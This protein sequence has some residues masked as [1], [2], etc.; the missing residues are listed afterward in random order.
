MDNDTKRKI[1]DMKITLKGRKR[2]NIRENFYRNCD[3]VD[4]LTMSKIFNITQKKFTVEVLDRNEE[5]FE[6][7]LFQDDISSGNN[8]IPLHC[9]VTD[10]YFE[11]PKYI[12]EHEVKVT[13]KSDSN[14]TPLYDVAEKSKLDVI[15]YSVKQGANVNDKDNNNRTPL[16]WAAVAGDLDVIII[17]RV[18]PILLGVLG[19]NDNNET[20]LYIAIWEGRSDVIKY[21]VKKGSNVNEKD[22]RNWTPLYIALE[23]SYLEFIRCMA[24]LGANVRR[25]MNIMKHLI[26]IS[27]IL[28]KYS[29]VKPKL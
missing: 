14:E 15:R 1:L 16:H 20:P 28:W 3:F 29:G 7:H 19:R 9:A 24:D 10:G 25:M 27:L 12:T 8:C 22:N 17:G 6:L 4:N 2:I 26:R 5:R 21:L 18:L 23:N 11:F 13:E